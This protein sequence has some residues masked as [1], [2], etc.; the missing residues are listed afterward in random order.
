MDIKFQSRQELDEEFQEFYLSSSL[1]GLKGGLTITLL[2]FLIYAVVSRLLF[3]ASVELLYFLKFGLILPFLLVFLLAAFIKPFRKHLGTIFSVLNLLI[4]L[5]IFYVGITSDI[6]SSAYNYFFAWVMLLI[7]GMHTFFRIRFRDLILLGGMQLIAYVLATTLNHT[8]SN[9]FTFVNNLF[10][11]ISVTSLGFFI[12][13]TFQSLNWKNFVHQK[14]LTENYHRLILEIKDRKDAQ[15]ELS[16]SERQYHE[17]LDSFP[18]WVIVADR[19][20]KI[21]MVNS[22]LNEVMR[23]VGITNLLYGAEI[24]SFPFINQD[25]I[26]DVKNVFE[27]GRISIHEMDLTFEGQ[28]INI[29]VRKIPVIRNNTV[30]QVM[31]VA[32]NRSREKEIET[33]KLRNAEQKE[34]MLKE[35][36]H[37]V[38]N[39]L[40]IVISLLEMQ[41]KKNPDANFSRIMKDIE[42]RIRSMALIHE[43]LYRSES[44]D[45]I[46]LSSYIHS[47]GSM[48]S[49]TFSKN[50][51]QL[52][53]N[54]DNIQADIETALPLGLISNE[55]LTNAYKY[56]FPDNAAGKVSVSLMKNEASGII[57]TISDNGI[58]LPEGFKA[59]NQDTL[60]MFIIKL[61]VE[62]LDGKISITSQKGVSAMISIP[63]V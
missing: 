1:T 47:L 31:V 32:R 38:K 42:L 3:G 48:V 34:I 59:E 5:L 50:N 56:A 36:H 8:W 57:L 11:V 41:D 15:E 61:L 43:H 17:A 25:E 7:I 10:F 62:Q 44:L 2:L 16:R 13:Y 22:T 28:E 18:D 14:A 6:N 21:I 26:D 39:N 46:P 23:S 24:T 9:H 33:L 35:I 45:K 49:G 60:G 19:D 58:G 54:L 53:M 30:E 51:I 40:A 63:V 29:E 4:C 37:R 52:E 55:L 12:S 27:T 20:F